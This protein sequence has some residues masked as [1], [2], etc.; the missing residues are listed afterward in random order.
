MYHATLEDCMELAQVDYTL[1][2]IRANEILER[3]AYYITTYRSAQGAKFNADTFIG[4]LTQDGFRSA[5][6]F[7]RQERHVW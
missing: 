3:L 5:G 4:R 7:N 1:G 2:V 6:S